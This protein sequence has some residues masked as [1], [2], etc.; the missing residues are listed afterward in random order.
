VPKLH[1]RPSR[2]ALR[3]HGYLLTAA[4]RDLQMNHGKRDYAGTM[5]ANRAGL[6]GPA[7]ADYVECCS[8]AAREDSIREPRFMSE[9]G[10]LA[11]VPSHD[12]PAPAERDKALTVR[13][14][15]TTCPRG[16]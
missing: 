5:P 10:G 15:E 2:A 11:T 8:T 4:N 6:R 1:D 3:F 13:Q 7:V 16:V 14:D 9:H 12:K